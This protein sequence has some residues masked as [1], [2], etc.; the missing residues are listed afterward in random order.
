MRSRRRIYD[1]SPQEQ[2][3]YFLAN[4]STNADGC[5]LWNGFRQKNGYVKTRIGGKSEWLHRVIF[6]LAG[7]HLP[8]KSDV[9]HTC[10]VRHC[11]EPTHLFAGTRLD[12]MQDAVKK[13]RQARGFALP[14]TKLANYDDLLARARA[15]ESYEAI[16]RTLG[17]SSQLVS[18]VARQ[19]GIFR[20]QASALDLVERMLAV[21][22][23]VGMGVAA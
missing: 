12:N 19:H 13:G 2:L 15:G 9:C 1:K 21:Q 5:R 20:Y 22:P 3:S 11:I 6:R 16:A 18:R 10:D 7:S 8:H 4:T 23:K 14:Q 17:I